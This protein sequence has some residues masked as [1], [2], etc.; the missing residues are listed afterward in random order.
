MR[1]MGYPGVS[2]H[3]E[4]SMETYTLLCVK[5]IAS[6]LSARFHTYL[7]LRLS[8]EEANTQKRTR[9]R[10]SIGGSLANVSYRLPSHLIVYY[11]NLLE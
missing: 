2:F 9:L 4:N 8:L 10:L 5:Q 11:N 6:E 3:P 7:Y 1:T